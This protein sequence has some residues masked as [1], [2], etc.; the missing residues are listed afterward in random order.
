[1]KCFFVESDGLFPLW[2]M[3]TDFHQA[4][5][6]RK[7]LIFLNIFFQSGPRLTWD[8]EQ[9][10]S[11]A[12]WQAN[13]HQELSGEAPAAAPDKW[14]LPRRVKTPLSARDSLVCHT[15][16]AR[17]ILCKHSLVAITDN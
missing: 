10:W 3:W 1:M 17:H 14:P 15:N 13:G 11:W 6:P 5:K 8:S 9:T 7:H 2:R 4:I 16:L 12:V